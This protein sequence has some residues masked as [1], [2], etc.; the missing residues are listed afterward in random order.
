MT[1]YCWPLAT[2]VSISECGWSWMGLWEA[3]MTDPNSV[4]SKT[5]LDG[6]GNFTLRVLSQ[7]ALTHDRCSIR[8]GDD[9]PQGSSLQGIS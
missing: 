5:L 7:E 8:Q 2:L 1:F 6:T 3:L 4:S 9:G